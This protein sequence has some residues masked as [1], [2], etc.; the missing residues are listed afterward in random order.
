MRR[1]FERIKRFF[2]RLFTT[3]SE[4]MKIDNVDELDWL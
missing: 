3:I 1:L 2:G 4:S